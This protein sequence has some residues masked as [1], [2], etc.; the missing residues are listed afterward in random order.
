MYLTKFATKLCA[1]NVRFIRWASLLQVS[2]WDSI[3]F[4]FN[5][6]TIEILQ[7]RQLLWSQYELLLPTL[8]S[9]YLRDRS[10]LM[11]RHNIIFYLFSL[12]NLVRWAPNMRAPEISLVCA[13][14]HGSR[15]RCHVNM[16]FSDDDRILAVTSN[17]CWNIATSTCLADYLIFGYFAFV[18]VASFF[19]ASCDV[20]A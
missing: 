18:C 9:Y 11:S 15:R 17:I 8:A 13:T 14:L 6:G 1:T 2:K 10:L 7:F 16:G 12:N 5:N 3:F 20:I 4:Q 19:L